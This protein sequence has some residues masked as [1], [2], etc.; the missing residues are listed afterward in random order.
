MSR[1]CLCNRCKC[2]LILNRVLG[3]AQLRGDIFL[4]CRSLTQYCYCF[5]SGSLRLSVTMIEMLV[6]IH[7]SCVK[8]I[9]RKINQN[10]KN[11][12]GVIVD[13]FQ[14]GLNVFIERREKV[15]SRQILFT[16]AIG[17]IWHFQ[18]RRKRKYSSLI[19]S[20]NSESQKCVC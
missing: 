11:K 19:D 3:C 6:N 10:K 16:K 5:T 14:R 18:R 7:E 17:D 12:K 4:W 8:N 13:L 9:S 20:A 15:E 2:T 1:L